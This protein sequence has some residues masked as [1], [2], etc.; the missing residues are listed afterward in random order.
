MLSEGEK[1]PM[2]EAYCPDCDRLIH[3]PSKPSVGDPVTCPHCRAKLEVI[4]LNPIELDWMY[5]D[6]EEEDFE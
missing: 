1:E 2:N 6:D 5:D 3:L 4:D